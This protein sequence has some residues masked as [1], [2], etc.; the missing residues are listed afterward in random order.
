MPY[1]LYY[2]PSI[3]GRGEF[4]RLA[5]EDAGVPY[6]DVCRDP[7][8]G[9]PA[10]LAVL[11]GQEAGLRPFAPPILKHGDM[12]V[13]QTALVLH[14]VAAAIGLVPKD[15]AGRLAAHQ[16]QLTIM[17]LVAEAHDTHHPVGTNLY[18]EDQKPEAER[19]ATGFLAARMPKYLSWLEDLVQ[20]GGGHPVGG[21]HTYVDLSVFQVLE[22]LAYAFP[23]G[24]AA[25]EPK[26]PGLVAVR[27]RV[28]ERSGI[29][30]YLASPRRIPFNEDGIFRRYPELD[31]P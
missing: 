12:L 30:A 20:R 16:V 13:A 11:K 26:V 14:Y 9:V 15:P 21:A 8:R 7:A 5:F 4:V 19:R 23:R 25:F 31:A 27:E 6:E 22:G 2:W 1:E 28:R 10:L 18:Y 24:F 17:D 3:Q 29:A